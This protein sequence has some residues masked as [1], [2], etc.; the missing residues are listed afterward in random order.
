[1]VV[2]EIVVAE[3][4]VGGGD[5]VVDD[6]ASSGES[7]LAQAPITRVSAIKAD[8]VR[9]IAIRRFKHAICPYA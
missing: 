2:G 4:V 7:P 3:S 8:E 1:M 5:V 6:N 9:A